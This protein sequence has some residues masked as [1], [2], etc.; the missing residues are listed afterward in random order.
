MVNTPALEI[1]SYE[2]VDRSL[3]RSWVLGFLS[4]PRDSQQMY[5][6]VSPS[7]PCQG[8]ASLMTRFY[9]QRAGYK[10]GPAEG[11]G[12]RALSALSH[13]SLLLLLFPHQ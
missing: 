7:P 12:A 5:L 4:D 13:P 3:W 11:A 9:S 6:D 2:D 10:V 8:Q 1:L